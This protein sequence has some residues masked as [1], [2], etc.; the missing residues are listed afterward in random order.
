MILS[1]NAQS[2]PSLQL[3][4]GALDGASVDWPIFHW[5]SMTREG[6]ARF[7]ERLAMKFLPATRHLQK[8]GTRQPV[9]A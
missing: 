6:H 1:R 9:S 5:E 3:E 8:D 7:W 2:L 4:A